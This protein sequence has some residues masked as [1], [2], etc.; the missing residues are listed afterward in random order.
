MLSYFIYFSFLLI[1]ILVISL[2]GK[3]TQNTKPFP[4]TS[5]E[6]EMSKLKEELEM[7]KEENEYYKA[8]LTNSTNLSTVLT[9]IRLGMK[10]TSSVEFLRNDLDIKKQKMMILKEKK[11]ILNEKMVLEHEK[12][13]IDRKKVEIQ[14]KYLTDA[15]ENGNDD[16][17]KVLK[18]KIRAAND[19]MLRMKE[20]NENL[21]LLKVKVQMLKES[22]RYL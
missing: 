2:Y 13:E 21:L 16:E 18:E 4:K 12:A 22:N 10:Q 8:K 1:L 19:K 7:L 9:G 3:P 5:Y 17:T 20:E 11:R 6:Q 15:F 14:L